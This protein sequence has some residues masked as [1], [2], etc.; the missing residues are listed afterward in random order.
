[1]CISKENEFRGARRE[2]NLKD[3][4][5]RVN[6]SPRRDNKLT[7][8]RTTLSFGLRGNQFCS[9]SSIL[10]S[11]SPRTVRTTHMPGCIYGDSDVGFTTV[12][13]FHYFKRYTCCMLNFIAPL[14]QIQ[15]L[16]FYNTY[17]SQ[18]KPQK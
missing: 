2:I 13:I 10:C 15:N 14:K 3:E 5:A 18:E 16:Y 7:A 12:V 17:C 4:I 6:C 9:Y 11:G 1:M 8:V